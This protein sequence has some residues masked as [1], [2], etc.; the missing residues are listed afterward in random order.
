MF[1]Y[2]VSI[3]RFFK[4][5]NY[6]ASN[7]S[8]NDDEV[9]DKAMVDEY[10][11]RYPPFPK[12][13]STAH[14]ETILK[15]NEEIIQQI[16]LARGLAGKHNEKDVDMKIL[17]PIRHLAETVH[18]LPAS[19]KNHF[20]TPGGLFRFS[21]ESALF[22]LR[23]SERRILT[24]V[25]PEIRRE[26]EALWAHA[27]FLTG[28]F[29]ESVLVISRISVYSEE[30][31]IEWHPGTESI[32][33]WMRRNQLK[34]YHIRWSEKEDRPMVYALAGKVIQTEQAEILAK[35]EK[36]IYKT[37][38]SA[39]HDQEDL[40]NPLVK[41]N[42]SV[43]YKLIERDEASDP[44]RYGK[45]LTGMHLD[46]WLIDAMRHLV[47]K[48]R[49]VVN[50]E[51]GRLW[52]GNDG[53]YLVWPLAA[54]DMQREL[55]DA[56]S[57]FVPNTKEILA[58]LM[59]EAGIVDHVGVDKDYLFDIAIPHLD[60]AER[61]HVSAIRL[62]RHEI[63][64]EKIAYKP[65]DINLRIDFAE[66]EG[67]QVIQSTSGVVI[68][69]EPDAT[70]ETINIEIKEACA[71]PEIMSDMS[72]QKIFASETAKYELDQNR[73][74]EITPSDNSIRTIKAAN[75]DIA[76]LL[77][78]Q[79]K[80]NGTLG[81]L[82]KSS[83]VDA[84]GVTIHYDDEY[85]QGYQNHDPVGYE[86]FPEESSGTNSVSAG[87][88]SN[89]VE[90]VL[91]V[92][93]KENML[94]PTTTKEVEDDTASLKVVYKIPSLSLL[95]TRESRITGYTETEQQEMSR[96]VEEILLNFRLD[97]K[98]VGVH[99]GPVI[100]LLELQPAAGIK[101]SRISN[102]DKDLAR[103]LS[104][105]SVRIVEVM[106]GKSVVG[107]EI[108]NREREI[109]CLREL[110]DSPTFIESE[111]VL[112][113]TVGKDVYGEPL[114][115][116]L[117]KMPHALVAGTTG[118]G[119]SVAINTMILSL[120]YKAT[121]QQVRLI[122][123]D[124]KMLELSVYED[125]PHLWMP[126]ITD[127]TEAKDALQKAVDEMERR[128]KLMSKVGAKH[129]TGFNQILQEANEQGRPILDPYFE[130]EQ[131][132]PGKTPQLSALPFIVIIIDELADMMMVDKKVEGLIVRL[133]QK[134]RAAGIHLILATQR[135]SSDVLTGLIKANI[136]AR[137]SFQVSSRTDSRTVLD[138]N[139]AEG[140]L[141]NGDMLFL[142]SGCTIPLRAHGAFVDDVEV[143]RVVEFL[144]NPSA[145]SYQDDSYYLKETLSNDVVDSHHND[146]I[147]MQTATEDSPEAH[148]AGIEEIPGDKNETGE[149]NSTQKLDDI[150]G[151]DIKKTNTEL[152]S[153]LFGVSTKEQ[154]NYSPLA[155][156]Q[157]KN[158]DFHARSGLVLSK[159][160]KIPMQH[161][162][163]MPGGITKVFAKGL[164][165]TNLN[166]KDC[167]SV[168]KADDLLMLVD[169]LDT[170]LDSS[171]KKQSQYFLVKDDLLD[172]S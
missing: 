168:L 108:P 117:G 125:I 136:P 63:L 37:L 51:N 83:S 48:K 112:T 159:L 95:N 25:T 31:G 91:K 43:K 145:E 102:L 24:R 2:V 49:W 79:D 5:S 118:S 80:Q 87:M 44:S 114:I 84:V 98:I 96:L 57:P 30:G 35:G 75:A 152:L 47:E 76:I 110:L 94:V 65:L 68:N 70:F 113:L 56:E 135:P 17:A 86:D 39:L 172:G 12:G 157:D 126:V 130:N 155:P 137:F 123:I 15:S 66:E 77:G 161:L 50:E 45:P 74:S 129:L 158:E 34:S 54:S 140:L 154:S 1:E 16:I 163:R 28:L 14:I 36:S 32:Y 64:F 107:L 105:S 46:P 116:D 85:A 169:G 121:P 148:N 58:E 92:V 109:V 111:S 21:L 166:L 60:S 41:I 10:V 42:R 61:K 97:V 11:Y 164:K 100:T 26:N 150:T 55:K 33:Q 23:Y 138:Q 6:S 13:L 156:T 69:K 133:A 19:E 82:E 88:Q 131:Y 147:E 119:K 103:A 62:V 127:M 170:G 99:S 89:N 149:V 171:K 120:L 18:L 3:F 142:P 139:G 122:M 167:V 141:G 144:K 160:K 8:V 73:A 40:N 146:F 151:T 81:E 153:G 78:K 7:S 106:P 162:E 38:F 9:V 128:Y 22:C 52:H 134:A 90:P 165:E 4:K 59:L 115:A 20:R 71:I 29:S 132:V 27:A 124:P 72:D 67:N 53:V 143:R 104:V 101:V 93:P